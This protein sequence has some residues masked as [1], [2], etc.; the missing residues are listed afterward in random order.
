MSKIT[1][2]RTIHIE[3]PDRLEE[4]QVTWIG[5]VSARENALMEAAGFG[6]QRW[7]Y[8]TVRHLS[9]R[10]HHPRPPA[11]RRSRRGSKMLSKRQVRLTGTRLL[12]ASATQ[13]QQGNLKT[14]FIKK[15]QAP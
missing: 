13:T 3:Q 8:F 14:F 4:A 11:I 2:Q 6:G 7:Y 9:A 5:Y 15:C 12:A 1:V 10:G